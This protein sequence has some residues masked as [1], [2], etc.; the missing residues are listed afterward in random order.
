MDDLAPCR[1]PVYPARGAGQ[2]TLGMQ[3]RTVL[4]ELYCYVVDTIGIWAGC[5]MVMLLLLA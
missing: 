4:G 5:C 3:R 1:T 2:D